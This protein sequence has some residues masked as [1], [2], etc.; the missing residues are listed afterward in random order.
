MN[1]FAGNMVYEHTDYA[2]TAD[3]MGFKVSHVYN[4]LY[5]YYGFNNVN[6][7]CANGLYRMRIHTG[8]YSSMY[9]GRGW[10]LNVYES[11]FL[12][13]ASGY[14]IYNDATGMEYYLK[15]TSSGTYIDEDGLGITVTASGQYYIMRY[16]DGSGQVKRF[17]NGMLYRIE[18]EDGN[19]IN[20]N[21]QTSNHLP[22]NAAP[23]TSIEQYSIGQ[24]NQNHR[25]IHIRQR[26]LP[27]LCQRPV[28]RHYHIYL[29]RHVERG[30]VFNP[31]IFI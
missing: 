26:P 23:I 30:A 4:S 8:N 9:V 17:Y 20:I 25:R 22:D 27:D 3:I 21:Y 12:D 24:S 6:T 29:Y 14:L 2:S 10:K 1:D 7:L 13:S 5:A 16:E 11:L 15:N 31:Y 18:D 28:R 19:Y